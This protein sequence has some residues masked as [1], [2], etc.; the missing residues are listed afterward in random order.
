M[1]SVFGRLDPQQGCRFAASEEGIVGLMHHR[2]FLRKQFG[3]SGNHR[4]ANAL[5]RIAQFTVVV[6]RS[7]CDDA[8]FVSSVTYSLV[9]VRFLA[10]RMLR[11]SFAPDCC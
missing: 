8:L 4:H 3:L 1:S 7:A 10:S 9:R 5:E 11:D 2:N 6:F